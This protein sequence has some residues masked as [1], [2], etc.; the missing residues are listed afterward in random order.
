[1]RALVKEKA[2]PGI[3]LRDI[4]EPEPGPND[5]LIRVRKTAICG[6]DIHIFNWDEWAAR[7]IPV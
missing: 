5:V 4:S 7:P 2:A 1:M 6:T 3:W